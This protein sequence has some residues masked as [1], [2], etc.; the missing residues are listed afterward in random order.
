MIWRPRCIMNPVIEP[1][2]PRMMTVPPFWSI[3]V[4]APT[5]PRTTTSPPR[6]AAAVSEP[7]LPSISHTPDIMFSHADQPD[8]T[9]DVNLGPVDQPAREVAE[10]AL[11][12]D[13]APRQDADPER[14]LRAR[15]RDR[16]VVHAQVVDEPPQLEVDLARRQIAGV[17][18]RAIAVDLG[19][20]GY[21]LVELDQAARVEARRRGYR[22]HTIT[23]LSYG[24]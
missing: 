1:T 22:V 23:S 21:A 11:E 18:A 16:D 17:E 7:A 24:S 15:V 2:S 5:R 8:A 12:R 3:P 4:R 9:G 10:A 19:G 20:P 6:N 13:L 14:V